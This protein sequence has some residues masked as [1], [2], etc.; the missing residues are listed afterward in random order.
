MKYF[1][2]LCMLI[3]LSSTA[4]ATDEEIL[5]GMV[6]DVPGVMADE[7][8]TT[9]V[10]ALFSYQGNHWQAFKCDAE[11]YTCLES[12][13]SNYPRKVS[14]YVGLDGRQIGEVVAKTPRRFKSYS[15]IGLQNI[16]EGN[17]PVIGKSSHEF[18]GFGGELVRRPLVAL[19]KPNFQDPQKWKRLRP[20]PEL[21]KQALQV[22]RNYAPAVCEEGG[23]ETSSL[24]AYNYGKDDINVRAHKSSSGSLLL[25]ISMSAYYCDGGD[26]DG[27][28]DDQMFAIDAAGGVHY[29]GAG[30]ILVDA[31]DYDGDG[32]SELIMSI[33]RYNRGGYALFSNTFIEQA[34]FEFGYH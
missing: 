28:Y 1:V 18:S 2:Y 7:S 15:H 29:L 34:R 6:E 12:I 21:I 20:T 24:I 13:N 26:G 4:W 31:G 14:W 30:L 9:K 10:R 32:T 19:S 23:D 16:I 11:N 8:H 25:T 27:L 22:M 17:A 5:L 33:S 3:A